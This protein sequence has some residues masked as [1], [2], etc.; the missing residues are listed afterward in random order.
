[1]ALEISLSCQCEIPLRLQP[2]GARCAERNDFMIAVTNDCRLGPHGLISREILHRHFS[3]LALHG[4]HKMTSP[5]ASIHKSRAISGNL[6][7]R[8]GEFRLPEEF[9]RL[10]EFPVILR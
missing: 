9:A 8:C 5:L 6:F 1:M 10:I 2:T 4:I 7:Q 3:A